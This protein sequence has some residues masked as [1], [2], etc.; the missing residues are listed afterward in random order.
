MVTAAIWDKN[1][2]IS[3]MFSQITFH[4][5]NE[6]CQYFSQILFEK[7]I[8][9]KIFHK[10]INDLRVFS[11]VYNTADTDDQKIV[12]QLNPHRV[13]MVTYFSQGQNTQNDILN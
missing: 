7:L 5:F 13:N 9:N 1:I 2:S 4:N 8:L 11:N 6:S 12:F 10:T 3:P